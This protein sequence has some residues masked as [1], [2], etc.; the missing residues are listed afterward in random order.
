MKDSSCFTKAKEG[1]WGPKGPRSKG[2]ENKTNRQ[3]SV[4][5]LFIRNR[6]TWR[7]YTPLTGCRTGIANNECLPFPWAKYRTVLLL[8]WRRQQDWNHPC[9]LSLPI[10]FHIHTISHSLTALPMPIVGWGLKVSLPKQPHGLKCLPVPVLSPILQS[11]RLF[12]KCAPDLSPTLKVISDLLSPKCFQ[13]FDSS[14]CCYWPLRRAC[15]SGNR[16][17]AS[18]ITPWHKGDRRRQCIGVSTLMSSGKP[19]LTICS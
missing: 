7:D 14:G 17:C 5:N 19:S 3:K 6:N 10:I 2:G 15:P 18:W 1:S 12:L 8:L 4:E 9:L 11:P 13:D 16:K